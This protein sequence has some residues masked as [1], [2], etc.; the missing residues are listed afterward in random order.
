MME[1]IQGESG[2]HKLDEN[3]VRQTIEYCQAN[4]ILF[5]VDEVQTGNGRTGYMYSYQGYGITPDIVTTAKGLGGGLPIGACL[6]FGKTAGVFS[7]GDHGTT[8]GGNPVAC[9][10]ESVS[11]KGLRKICCS[12]YRQKEITLK[13]LF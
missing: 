12:K 3:F 9:A 5:I 8:F 7:Y 4:D 11:S 6:L 13:H 10:G 2:V 1:L